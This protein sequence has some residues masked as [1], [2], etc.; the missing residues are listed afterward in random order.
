[1]KVSSIFMKHSLFLNASLKNLLCYIR[2]KVLTWSVLTLFA[3]CHCKVYSPCEGPSLRCAVQNYISVLSHRK[4]VISSFDF[5]WTLGKNIAYP[6]LSIKNKTHSLIRWHWSLDLKLKDFGR[7]SS[8]PGIPLHL[9]EYSGIPN[10]IYLF[11]NIL[12]YKVSEHIS[13]TSCW[14]RNIKIEQSLSKSS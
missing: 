14:S 12:I 8:M 5:I 1:M 7:Y 3:N 6:L 11:I 10:L 2:L 9:T 4:Y 13:Y